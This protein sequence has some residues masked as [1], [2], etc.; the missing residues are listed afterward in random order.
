MKAQLGQKEFKLVYNGDGSPHV[1]E[2]RF[3]EN[4]TLV[5][6]GTSPN[7]AIRKARRYGV[8]GPIK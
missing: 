5:T 8:T 3:A 1:W 4:N 2:V 7:S 6:R